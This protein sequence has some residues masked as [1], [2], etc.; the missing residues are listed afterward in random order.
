MSAALSVVSYAPNRT[1]RVID[2]DHAKLEG[3]EL[4]AKRVLEG[5]GFTARKIP[6]TSEKTADFDVRGDAPAYLVEVKSRLLDVRLANPTESIGEV[7]KSMRRDAK[8]G[9]W[10]ADAKQQF[11]TRDPDHARLWF[12]WC[13]MESPLSGMNQVERTLSVLY[14]VQET[15]D[16][17]PP[18]RSAVIFYATPAAFDRFPEIDGAV[19]VLPEIGGLTF[20]PNEGSPRFGA[21]MGSRLVRELREKGVGPMLPSERAAAVGGHVVPAAL[22]GADCA[23]VLQHVQEVLGSR[24]VNFMAAEV[25]Y[26]LTGRIVVPEADD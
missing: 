7:T 5:L 24:Y 22:R 26:M 15:F 25:E 9:D 1:S 3:A 6:T 13:S 11:R 16:L 23:K 2:A 21:V 18:H 20:C 8:V 19:V 14:G 4:D 10:L 17:E 12:L